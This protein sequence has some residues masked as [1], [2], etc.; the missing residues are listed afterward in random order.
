MSENENKLSGMIAFDLDGMSSTEIRDMF[1]KVS[2][3]SLPMW[4]SYYK[5]KD[6]LEVCRIIQS[7][8]DYKNGDLVKPE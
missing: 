7:I 3:K 8:A 5:A 4:L 6:E 1:F 2:V